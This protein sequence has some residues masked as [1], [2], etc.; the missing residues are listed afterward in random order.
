[1]DKTVL[2]TI[3][4]APIAVPIAFWVLTRP[5]K[6]FH[7]YLWKRLPEGF[8]RRLLLRK[9]SDKVLPPYVDPTKY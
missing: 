6:A 2:V 8:W 7:N 3:A 9:V 4:T 1:M 5:G